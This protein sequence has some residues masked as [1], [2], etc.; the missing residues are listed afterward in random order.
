MLSLE[1]KYWEAGHEHVAGVDEVG[2]GC[3]FGPV[4]VAA[5]VF[6]RGSTETSLPKCR[7]SKKLSPKRREAL[8]SELMDLQRRGGGGEG[9]GVGVRI[10]IAI[11]SVEEID[12]LNI[13]H[14]TL[15]CFSRA[16][17]TLLLLPLN[18]P[19]TVALIDGN[20]LPTES[21]HGWPP[22]CKPIA[23]VSGDAISL[24]IA[25]AS[26]V[27]KVTRD[28]MMRDLATLQ[29]PQ[30]LG[31]YEIQQNKGYPTKA[32]R[33]AVRAHGLTEYHRKTFNCGGSVNNNT[34]S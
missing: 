22:T 19:P 18:T 1:S 14:A 33:D 27:A 15:S 3:I 6:P 29:H 10:S 20:Q 7:D 12:R 34:T 28:A 32:H 9:G 13:L 24:S 16:V 30:L 21:R 8:Y 26:I 11:G 4:V 17:K 25:A 5:V 2:R 31:P 23:V